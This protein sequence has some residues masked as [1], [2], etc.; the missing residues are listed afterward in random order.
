[1]HHAFTNIHEKDPDHFMKSRNL[2]E[3]A[4]KAI[5]MPHHWFFWL[6][7][8]GRLKKADIVELVLN[9]LAIALLHGLILSVVGAE[10]FFWG[11]VPPLALVSLMLW[12]PFAV[13]THEGFSTGTAESRSHNYYGH[14][15]FWFSLGLSM[16]REHH[17]K[18]KLAWIELLPFVEKT[19]RQSFS[20]WPHRDIKLDTSQ[21]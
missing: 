3:L 4:L 21:S 20:L 9:Y 6:R 7:R 15:M 16:H 12:Y 5:A 8:R 10:R 13:Q 17:L 14:F 19:S 11:I 1:M 18:P 2:A